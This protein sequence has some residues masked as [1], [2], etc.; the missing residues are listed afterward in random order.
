MEE[1]H[2]RVAEEGE[3]DPLLDEQQ[4][5]VVEVEVDH[6]DQDAL[7]AQV[8][9]VVSVVVAV[10][11][12]LVEEQYRG[13]FG[14][15]ERHL[16]RPVRPVG[17]AVVP[18]PRRPEEDYVVWQE[19]EVPPFACPPAG[20]RSGRLPAV[21]GR[22]LPGLSPTLPMIPTSGPAPT[23]TRAAPPPAPA[24]SPPHR[25]RESGVGGDVVDGPAGPARAVCS[26]RPAPAAAQPGYP[27]RGALRSAPAPAPV[28]RSPRPPPSVPQLWAAALLP[29]PRLPFLTPAAH[30]SS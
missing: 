5:G 23:P 18:G 30:P 2:E 21:D 29:R 16:P 12:K 22:A 1:S 27:P 7:V 19:V 13:L 17:E 4:Q 20:P 14:E 26:R 10:V 9:E 3:H 25:I 8:Q 28:R 15:L 11:E 24:S 6:E